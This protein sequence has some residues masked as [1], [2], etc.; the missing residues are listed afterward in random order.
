M[1]GHE[2]QHRTPIKI[3]STPIAEGLDSPNQARR[4]RNGCRRGGIPL[5]DFEDCSVIASRAGQ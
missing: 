4:S 1:R 2:S 5:T 3:E